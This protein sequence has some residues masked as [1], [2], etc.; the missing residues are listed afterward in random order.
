MQP[1]F[2]KHSA[3]LGYNEHITGDARRKVARLTGNDHGF[4]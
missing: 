3:R 2:L 1:T 4:R